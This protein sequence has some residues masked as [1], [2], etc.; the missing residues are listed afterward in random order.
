MIEVHSRA[1]KRRCQAPA[2]DRALERPFV[3]RADQPAFFGERHEVRGGEAAARMLPAHERLDARDRAARAAHH[4][5]P[6]QQELTA[7]ESRAQLILQ[8]QALG[9]ARVKRRREATPRALLLRVVERGVRVLEELD[10]IATI[11]RVDA[12]ADGSRDV[13]RLA[14]DRER[15]GEDAENA[16]RHGGGLVGRLDRVH[17]DEVVAA[18]ARERVFAAH[19]IAEALGHER[20]SASPA[21]WPS[22]S[23]TSLKRSR[24]MHRSANCARR[25]AEDRVARAVGEQRRIGQSRQG[26]ARG[27]VLDARLGMLASGDVR[28]GAAPAADAAF[29]VP[30]RHAA[31]RQPDHSAGLRNHAMQE[32]AEGFAFGD[33]PA[34]RPPAARRAA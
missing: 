22:D 2:C 32:I 29:G 20:S 6:V 33:T 13:E 17:E 34:A 16:L 4:R 24:S 12:D 3:D 30:H 8:A 27:E 15:P 1:P 31:R 18:Q 25:A 26:V 5:L 10:E 11:V 28:A 21:R 9:G 7:R 19:E 14:L 23:F